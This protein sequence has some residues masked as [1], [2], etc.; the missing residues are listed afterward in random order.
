MLQWAFFQL[1]IKNLPV[2]VG[3]ESGFSVNIPILASQIVRAVHK[4]PDSVVNLEAV[5]AGLIREE[6]ARYRNM[7]LRQ[8]IGNAENF[9]YQLRREEDESDAGG[10]WVMTEKA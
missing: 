2:M 9:L 5:V 3:C 6:A 8:S 7:E 10:P 1:T 4:S